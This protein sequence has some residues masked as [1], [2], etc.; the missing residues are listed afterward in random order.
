MNKSQSEI[1]EELKKENAELKRLVKSLKFHQGIDS[2][3]LSFHERNMA[4][5]AADLLINPKPIIIHGTEKGTGN[6]YPISLSNIVLI[7]SKKR[8]KVIYLNKPVIPVEGGKTKSKIET[9]NSFD[10]LLKHMQGSGHHILRS[11]DKYAINIYHYVLSEK[12]KFNLIGDLPK[13][14]SEKLRSIK[15]DKK[16]DKELYYTRLLEIDR[17]N[18]LHQDFAVNLKKIEEISRYKNR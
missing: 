7:E 1:I 9:E 13:S 14:M 4:S 2:V 15:T 10:I 11:S 17:L 16:F 18:K 12:G 8:T 5:S 3:L 6:D